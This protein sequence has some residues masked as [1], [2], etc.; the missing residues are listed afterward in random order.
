MDIPKKAA[1]ARART[2]GFIAWFLAGSG[3]LLFSIAILVYG[4]HIG[5]TQSADSE[6]WA[7]FGEFVGGF[8]GA[9]ISLMAL[10][11]LALNLRLQAQELSETSLALKSQAKSSLEQQHLSFFFELLRERRAVI[12]GLTFGSQ[13][14]RIAFDSLAI[15]LHTVARRSSDTGQVF[16]E[17]MSDEYL[18]LAA[19]LQPIIAVH[20]EMLQLMDRLDADSESRPLGQQFSNTYA[21]TLTSPELAVI[22]YYGLTPLGRETL[23]PLMRTHAVFRTRSREE[24]CKYLEPAWLNRYKP[25][26]YGRSAT[27]E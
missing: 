3:C 6:D 9:A 4:R 20:S 10:I 17:F 11:A 26:F 15:R 27:W 18:H 5:W 12:D 16:G 1:L 21:N 22:F 8:T 25:A 7:R 24:L 13:V 2:Y 19:I 23:S 14:G